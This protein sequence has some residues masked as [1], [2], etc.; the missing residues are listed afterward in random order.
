MNLY[1]VVELDQGTSAWLE[2]RHQGIGASDAPTIMGENPWKDPLELLQEKSSPPRE[3]PQNEAMRR[4]TQLEPIARSSYIST[5]G[6]DVSPACIQSVEHAWWRAS[7]DGLS[8]DGNHVIEI[9]CG[10]SAYRKTA[11]YGEPP[12]YYYGQLQ[13]ILGI[14]G[15]ST[16]DFWCYLP[17]RPEILV[18]VPRNNSYIERLFQTEHEFWQKVQENV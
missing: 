9:K 8:A 17:E 6:I 1:K 7:V 3:S 13:H 5:V 15:I 16:I 4:G 14:T 12:D 2:W 11:E 18:S 10:E